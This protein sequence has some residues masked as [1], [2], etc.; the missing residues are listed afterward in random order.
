M[1]DKNS[2]QKP[3]PAD[4]AALE[5]AFAS[6]P[7]SDAY[8]QLAEA[9]LALGRHMEAMVVGK[10]GVRA[11]PDDPRGRLLLAR[12]YEAQGKEKKAL[13]ELQAALQ[14]DPAHAPTLRMAID[15]HLRQ[16]ATGEAEALLRA[17]AAVAPDRKALEAIAGDFGLALPA[18][19]APAAPE[20]AAAPQPAPVAAAAPVAQAAAGAPAAP[21]V[22]TPVQPPVEVVRFPAKQPPA[23]PPAAPPPVPQAAPPREVGAPVPAAAPTAA[24]GWYDDEED[25]VR[26]RQHAK[27][28]LVRLVATLSVLAVGLIGW[29]GYT[30]WTADRDR[31]IEKLLTE[32]NDQ[33]RRDTYASYKKA[34]E[35]AE[36]ILELDS[37]NA[38]AHAYLAYINA[39]RWGEQGEGEDFQ[40]RAQE[41]LEKAKRA[42]TEHSRRYAAEAYLLYFSGEGKK[43]EELL[44]QV[45]ASQRS[46]VLYTTLGL[47]Q[48]GGGDLDKAAAS[49]EEAQRLEPNS[50]RTLAALGQLHRRRGMDIKAWTL[51]DSALRI[52]PEH[53]D[54]LL[55]KALLV[56]DA[57]EA[58]LSRSDRDKLLAEAEQQID[59]VLGLP[60]GS[61]S[62][63]QLALGK[64]ARAQLLYAR[65]RQAEAARLEQEAFTL[66]PSN[67]DMRLMR[68]RRMLR[69][70][71]IDGAVAEIRAAIERDPHRASFYVDLSRALLAKRGG[72][73]EAVEALQT[74]REKFPRSGR[75]ALLL[76]DA[77]RAVPD[78]ERARASY[79]QAIEI[80]GGRFPEARAKL[81]SIWREKKEWAKA[82][83][84]LERAIEE[85]GVGAVGPN[86]AY[87]LTELGR[88]LEE[89][90]EPDVKAAFE[91]Y[92]R[93][94]R[95]AESF[96][97][98]Y[99]HVGRLS[100]AAARRDAEQRKQALEALQRYLELSPKGEN[101]EEARTLLARIR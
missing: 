97:P 56:L 27:R 59:K 93:A 99:Y 88:V 78:V 76:G 51:Y 11:H 5:H 14:K 22:L 44:E 89:G 55:G 94:T 63:R 24:S 46:G 57:N 64:F 48:M 15:L 82:R 19:P 90:P 17:A 42:G 54:S 38:V 36:G 98:P 13:D 30:R 40:R 91:R 6:D 32:T 16:G 86:V 23:A 33:I 26:S 101:A 8:L 73:R 71:Q 68:G 25:E 12:V 58:D 67:A 74:A 28:G 29:F 53:A 96:A 92:A 60:D 84:E 79:E 18:P 34:S 70:G 85:F 35:A 72:A 80:E 7:A 10:K 43:A 9:Y 81:G 66:D 77:W 75:I 20:P 52:D 49:L 65:D 62:A 47:I 37:G 61:I 2:P 69:E 95:V 3:S 50:V 39:L 21:P 87:A 83:Q 4:L 31:Q 1:A 45:L 41:S 100:A